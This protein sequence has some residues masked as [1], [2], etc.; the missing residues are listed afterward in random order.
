MFV[1]PP[2]SHARP[3]APW[4]ALGPTAVA[5]AHC[6]SGAPPR[7]CGRPRAPRPRCCKSGDCNCSS[8]SDR[9][10]AIIP[11]AMVSTCH[12]NACHAMPWHAK[13][14]HAMAS[15]LL[16]SRAGRCRVT[17]FV[18]NYYCKTGYK[19]PYTYIYIYI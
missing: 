13:P 5:V 17:V 9:R 1:T 10:A 16:A 8:D 6:S 4:M 12:G 18:H 19:Y 2:Q 14:C 7:P 15:C 3:Q 11:L